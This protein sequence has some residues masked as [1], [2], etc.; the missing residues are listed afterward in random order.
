MWRHI[1]AG[2]L[3]EGIRNIILTTVGRN[4]LEK[5]YAGMVANWKSS[6][7]FAPQMLGQ[8]GIFNFFFQFG[9]LSKAHTLQFI[10][11]LTIPSSHCGFIH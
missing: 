11:G 3:W 7:K 4:G 9:I 6:P 5:G 10:L 1:M 2:L 8:C